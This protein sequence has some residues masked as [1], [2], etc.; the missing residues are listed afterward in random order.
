MQQSAKYKH[1]IQRVKLQ[2]PADKFCCISD[3][4]SVLLQWDF[5]FVTVT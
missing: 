5:K 3:I 4:G 1:R 2:R